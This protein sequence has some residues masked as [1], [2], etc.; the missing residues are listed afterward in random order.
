MLNEVV[1]IV[2]FKNLRRSSRGV[3]ACFHAAP[4]LLFNLF[5]TV[6]NTKH[7][8][9]RASQAIN[10]CNTSSMLVFGI[11]IQLAIGTAKIYNGQNSDH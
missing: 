3:N 4:E 10:A 5:S 7:Q 6:K 2:G 8:H 9:W 1:E 11:L